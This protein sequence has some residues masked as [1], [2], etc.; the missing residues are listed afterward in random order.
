MTRQSKKQFFAIL[1]CVCFIASSLL[2]TTFIIRHADHDCAGHD[3]PV[4]AQIHSAV[5]LLKQFGMGM[6][7]L[8]F[9]FVFAD[10]FATLNH[11]SSV[12]LHI[13]LATPVTLKVRMNN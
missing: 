4:C 13:D 9:A 12:T 11:F 2:T 5:N 1:F 8:T 6:A 7:C 3:C 10:L